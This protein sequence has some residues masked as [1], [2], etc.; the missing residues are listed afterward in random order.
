[1][2][3]P[4]R[5]VTGI[6][7][8]SRAVRPGSLFVARHEKGY[9]ADGHQYIPIAAAQGAVAAVVEPDYLSGNPHPGLPLIVTPDSGAALADFA[10]AFYGYPARKLRVVGVTGTDGKT[11]TTFLISK[12]LEQGGHKTGLFGTVYFKVGTR[13]W[14]NPTRATTPEAVEVQEL[15]AEM[16][17]DGCD[18]AVLESSSHGLA[19]H[20]LDHCEYDVA[21]L[22]N[23]TH[24]HLDFHGTVEEYQLAKA[25]L[26]DFL[27]TSMDK[28]IVKVGVVNLDDP[29][30][31]MYIERVPANGRTLTYA[32]QNEHADVCALN[33]VASANGLRYT[34]AT[35]VGNLDLELMLTGSFNV[36]NSLA[37]IAVGISQNVSLAEIKA[38]LEQVPGVAGR[39]EQIQAGQDFTCIVD[40]A[41]TPDALNKVLGILRPLTQGKLIAVIGSAGERDLAKRPLLG[42]AAAK[43]CDFFVIADEDPRFEPPMKI[44]NEIAA[45]AEAKGKQEGRDFLKIADRR[46]AIAA[47]F[48]C[49]ATG[50]IVALLGK[51][52]EQCIIVGKD[53][54]PWDDRS[55][56]RELLE[57]MR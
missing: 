23:V 9:R 41:H 36:Y 18:Y 55:V 47:A 28:G 46:T 7:Y 39:M 33:V 3:A 21:V 31:K 57:G 5:E 17:A 13:L 24:E 4:E 37:A 20:R 26:F 25:K 2:D 56:A 19:Q 14:D 27:A 52:H 8:D 45:G 1:A 49:A 30:A 54:L 34:A 29:N 22:T 48:D 40:Y 11:T 43:W 32:V 12:V 42:A 44:I 35:P 38:A 15:L 50:D 51:G 16:V 6:A 10:A 53:K